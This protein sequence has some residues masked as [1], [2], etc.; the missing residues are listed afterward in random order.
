MYY[1]KTFRTKWHDTD[2]G[3]CLRPSAVVMYMQ[4]TANLQLREWGCDVNSLHHDRR[5]GF[6]LSRIALRIEKPIHAYEDIEVRTWCPP[7][8]ALTF[9]RCFSIHR[10]GETVA[11][12]LSHWGLMDIERGKLLRVSEFPDE[13]FPMGEMPDES[14]IPHR[15]HI[16]VG[17][18]LGEVGERRIVYSDLDFNSH[19]N[20]TKYPDMIC[21]FLPDMQGRRVRSLAMSYLHEAAKGDTLTVL[22]TSVACENGNEGYLLRT[23][24][25]D[26]TVC[27]EAEVEL[28][29]D[30]D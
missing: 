20:N 3:G 10:G 26:G 27:L 17:T 4:E 1:A 5:M 8:R 12:A 6:L 19:M 30:K 21:D 22:R 25:A 15:V 23:M 13:C 14:L 2:A 24:R 7:S 28:C 11:L 9:L 29:A 16:P 18:V